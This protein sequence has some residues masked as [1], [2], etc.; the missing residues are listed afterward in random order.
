MA[1]ARD[2]LPIYTWCHCGLCIIRLTGTLATGTALAAARF[3]RPGPDWLPTKPS[4]SY[5]VGNRGKIGCFTQID[6]GRLA[7]RVTQGGP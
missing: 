3:R 1:Y 6:G 7:K 2:V 5:G 4:P